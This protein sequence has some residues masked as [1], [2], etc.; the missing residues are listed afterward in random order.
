MMILWERQRGPA[1]NPND[2][3]S[4][5]IRR[6]NGYAVLEVRMRGGEKHQVKHTPECFD[7]DD[8]YVLHKQLLEAQ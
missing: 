4:M 3:S 5:G 1:V 8:V 7:G 2:V 6:S